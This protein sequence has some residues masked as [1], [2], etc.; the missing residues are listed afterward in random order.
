MLTAR[1]VFWRLVFCVLFVFAGSQ[2]FINRVAEIS[3]MPHWVPV[4]TVV[5]V[6]VGL[7]EIAG[8]IGI[9]I[10][11]LRRA[12]GIGLILLLICV[13]PANVAM[14]THETGLKGV[15]IP[16]VILWLRLPLQL[17]L[18]YGVYLAA[19]AQRRSTRV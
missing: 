3:I 17:F 7:C 11:G 9:L 8:G 15:H 16:N 10:P 13:F 12:A 2:H 14:A 18:M 5:N 6:F 1:T 19:L 4:K